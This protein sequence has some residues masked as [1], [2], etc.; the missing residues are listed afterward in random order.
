MMELSFDWKK[1]CW[2][3]GEQSAPVNDSLLAPIKN[4]SNW[5][6]PKACQLKR[7]FPAGEP[8]QGVAVFSV[9]RLSA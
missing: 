7:C 3:F 4:S 2:I 9:E 1:K 5:N 6:L 8:I